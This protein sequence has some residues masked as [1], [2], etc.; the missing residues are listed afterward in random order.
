MGMVHDRLAFDRGMARGVAAFRWAALLWAWIGLILERDQ[1]EHRWLAIAALSVASAVTAF[2][3]ARA[4]R[5]AA[6]LFA[7]WFVVLEVSVG[8]GLLLL[9]GVVYDS[10]RQQSLPW[11]WPAAGIITAAVVWGTR[12]GLVAAGMAAV[13]SF[14]GESILRDAVEW[15]VSAASKS[16]L[17]A[18]AAIA[19]GTVAARLREAEGEISTVRAREEVA[20]TLH[21]GVLQTLAVIQRRSDDREL[22][23]LARSQERDLRTFLFGRDRAVTDLAAAVR[24]SVDLVAR[25]DGIDVEVALADDLPQLPDASVRALAGAVQEAVTNA[26]KHSGAA[27]VVVYAEPT[28]DERGVFCSVRDD[29]RGFDVAATGEGEGLRGSIRGRIADAGGRVEIDSS[30]GRGTEVRLWIQ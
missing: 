27:R 22:C 18:L 20:R 13:A 7:R 15:S 10:A 14:V 29:G 24:A 26:A 2:A 19:A 9:D 1:L 28:S 5:E 4:A 21:D 6:A 25:R 8:L 17:F 11:A 23:D 16:A 3:T 30:P 12:G